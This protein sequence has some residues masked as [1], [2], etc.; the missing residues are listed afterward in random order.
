[1][2]DNRFSKQGKSTYKGKTFRCSCCG[3]NAIRRPDPSNDTN[4]NG[5]WAPNRRA[6]RYFTADGDQK[7]GKLC[8]ACMDLVKLAEAANV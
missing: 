8:D 5:Y 7:T 4:E 6:V 2:S 3:K 1:M